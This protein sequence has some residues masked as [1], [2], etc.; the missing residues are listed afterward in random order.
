M[1]YQDNGNSVGLISSY[2]TSDGEKHLMADVT[3]A[4]VNPSAPT[5]TLAS[6]ASQKSQAVLSVEPTV[7]QQ[8]VA[9]LVDA[10]SSFGQKATFKNDP[11]L[12]TDTASTTATSGTRAAITTISSTTSQLVQALRQFDANGNPIAGPA[13]AVNGLNTTDPSKTAANA[14]GVLA[15]GRG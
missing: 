15:I 11:G 12:S 8:G 1:S 4:A 6:P 2:T 7:M 5:P 10:L 9:S 13:N 3:F 14:A